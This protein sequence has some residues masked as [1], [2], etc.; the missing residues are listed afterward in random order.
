MK[1]PTNLKLYQGL[2]YQLDRFGAPTFEV[3]E[4]NYW[5]NF[6]T[7]KFIN[8]TL[9]VFDL[10]QKVSDALRVLIEP[11]EE[12]LNPD[13][14]TDVRKFT[15]KENYY[16]LLNCVFKI[17]FK[18]ARDCFKKADTVLYAAKRMTADLASF[19]L[20]NTYHKPQYNRPYYQVV[21]SDL[22]LTID[23]GD[24]PDTGVVI[25]K[26]N[27]NYIK[28][29]NVIKLFPSFNPNDESAE[30]KCNFPE[31]ITDE[32]T[33]LCLKLILERQGDVSRLQTN[34][35]LDIN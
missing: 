31:E 17:R 29:P 26:V 22:V 12:V 1:A 25:E 3:P 8:K 18:E 34:T 4:F 5:W 20:K 6:A 24:F 27:Y 19:A 32:I 28:A 16:R 2:L 11:G 23:T 21:G 15:L 35:S 10:T 33:K 9:D 14:S 13:D 30:E 7:R